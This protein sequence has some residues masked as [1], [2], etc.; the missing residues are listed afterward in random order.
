MYPKTDASP[1]GENPACL[2]SD[3]LVFDTIYNPLK[4]KLLQQAKQAGAKTIGGIEMF[5]RQA[6]AQF[7]LW[8]GQKA[9]TDLMRRVIERK[10]SS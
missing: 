5:V 8:T 6:A 9:P 2:T 1:L 7:Q 10:L 3:T 4:T